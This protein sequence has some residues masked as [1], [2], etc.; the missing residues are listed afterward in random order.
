[1]KG[2]N[3]DVDAFFPWSLGLFAY[4]STRMHA[5]TTVDER[6]RETLCLEYLTAR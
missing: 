2:N 4:K 6:M 5:V 1:M 3:S